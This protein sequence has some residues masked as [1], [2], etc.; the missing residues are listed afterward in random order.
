MS[1]PSFLLQ[2]KD[3]GFPAF[4]T[5]RRSRQK[6]QETYPE[7]LATGIIGKRRVKK[8]NEYREFAKSG[9]QDVTEPTV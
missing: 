6:I 2:M 7:L 5:V 4:E 8:E 3:Y 9:I 1:V